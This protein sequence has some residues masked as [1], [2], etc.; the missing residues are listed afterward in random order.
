MIELY[1]YL[2]QKFRQFAIKQQIQGMAGLDPM[3]A[4]ARQIPP[5][6]TEHPGTVDGSKTSGY[7]LLNFCHADIAFAQII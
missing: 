5:D 4:T 2:H 6:A 7:L 1:Y 3:F